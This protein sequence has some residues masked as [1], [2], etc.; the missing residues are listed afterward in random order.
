VSKDWASRAALPPHVVDLI[1]NFPK[2][3]HPMSQLV[4]AVAALQTESKFA[5]AYNEKTIKKVGKGSG[6]EIS[7]GS[8]SFSPFSHFLCNTERLLGDDL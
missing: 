6:S 8:N 2:T 5:K 1:A 3:M 4:A 7:S